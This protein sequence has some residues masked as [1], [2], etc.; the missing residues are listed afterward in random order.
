M[1]IAAQPVQLSGAGPVIPR[2]SG[3]TRFLPNFPGAVMASGLLPPSGGLVAPKAYALTWVVDVGVSGPDHPSAACAP[4]ASGLGYPG[5]A[6][7]EDT[8]GGA[9]R[10]ALGLIFAALTA[11]ASPAL[12]SEPV[13]FPQEVM[14]ALL[15]GVY[16][17]APVWVGLSANGALVEIHGNESTST[18]TL[19]VIDP[20][21]KACIGGAGGMFMIVPPEINGDPA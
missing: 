14:R 12:A 8:R 7:P 5:R 11:L 2:A 19:V 3:N 9:Q 1:A 18:W 13:C 4:H 20:A 15:S 21:G 10:S 17:E 6:H 16:G